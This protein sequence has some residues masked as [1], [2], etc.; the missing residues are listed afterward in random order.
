MDRL[1]VLPADDR[2]LVAPRLVEVAVGVDEQLEVGLVAPLGVLAPDV[3]EVGGE[4]FVEPGL[5]PLAAGQQ[6]APPLVRQLVRD[7][8]LDVVIERGA[9]VEQREVGQRRRGGV[10][11]A[12][13]D[14]LGHG[15]LAVA[16]MG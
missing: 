2:P 4:A 9:L 1:V 11:H 12:A 3:L 10:L 13:E 5:G 16:R 6:I 15:D 7:Q 14:E 8:R